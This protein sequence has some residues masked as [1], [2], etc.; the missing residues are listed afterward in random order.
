MKF[1]GGILGSTMKNWLNFG[2]DLGILRRVNEQKENTIIVVAYPDPG[3][4]NDP[5]LF[6]SS[7]GGGGGEGE[8][9]SLSPPRL[10]IL[11]VGNMGVMICL[12][13]GG[14]RSQSASS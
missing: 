4:G 1:Y 7:G 8:G 9:S 12:N 10:N 2:G 14:L 5:R 13:Q 6:F 3:A 11:T